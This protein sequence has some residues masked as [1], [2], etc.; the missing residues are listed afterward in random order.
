MSTR[1][2]ALALGVL[3][4]GGALAHASQRRVDPLRRDT[5]AGQAMLFA[6]DG[7]TL[8][9]GALDYHVHLADLLWV[10]TVLSFG[11]RF[12]S[13]DQDEAWG[14]WFAIS[15]HA[16]S[17]LDP[18]WRTPYV[19]G[20]SMLRV[21]GL[22][23]ESTR[24]FEA[25]VQAL[26]QDWY[27]PFAVGMNHYLHHQDPEEAARWLERASALPGAPAWYAVAAVAFREGQYQRQQAIHY[28]R[29]ELAAT[30]D[31]NLRT[32]LEGRLQ[33]LMHDELAEQLTG[34]AAELAERR[35]RPV[36]DPAELV[37]ARR[38]PELP[39]DPRGGTWVVD[40][41]GQIR[42]SVVAE[43]QALVARRRERSMLRAMR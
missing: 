43:E 35:G 13:E 25:G 21:M 23:D 8:R 20:G 28:L 26:P 33:G 7:P 11:E 32:A 6:P 12:G 30:T 39:P 34:L 1:S 14:R 2:T 4:A 29:D 42:S 5:T 9:V 31:P 37:R 27:L 41:D 16:V 18:A 36:Q 40:V 24:L 17:T 15:T 3:L 38:L 10:R 22:N 19:Y